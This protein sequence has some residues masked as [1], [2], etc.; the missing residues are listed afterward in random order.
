MDELEPVD[1]TK[2]DIN[3]DGGP[4]EPDEDEDNRPSS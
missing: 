4:L 1:P 3:V 2:V